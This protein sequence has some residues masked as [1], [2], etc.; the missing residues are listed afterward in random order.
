MT[1]QLNSKVVAAEAAKALKDDFRGNIVL[2]GEPSYEQARKVWNGMIDKHP[3]I[4]LRCAGTSDVMKAVRFA[5]D[6]G[7][8]VSVR[9]GGHNVAGN[10]VCDDGLMIDLSGMKS[11]RVD[12]VS[13]TVRVEPGATW[14][15]FD[16]E[17]QAFG[18]AATGGLVSTTGIAGFTL[19]G[20]IGWLVRKYGLALDN[21]VSVDVV[22]ARSEL[23]TASMSENTDLFWG[24][25]GGG[26]NF[27]IVT[28]FE[29]QLYPVGPIV[30]G[31]LIAYKAEDGQA[32]LRFYRDYVK[33]APDELTTI[34]VYLTAPP[35]PFLPKEVHGT[36]LLAIAVCYCGGIE[37]GQRVLAPLRKFGKPV[38]DVIQPL[39]Y[40]VLQSMLD[41]TSPAGIQN[42][43]KS[44]YISDLSDDAID[45]ILS[46][47]KKIASPLSAVHMHQ[48]GGAMRRVGD[49]A[50]AFSHRDASCLLNIVS[51]WQDPVE[52]EKQIK[53]T[54]DF[55]AA[56]KR[57]SIGAY[58]NFLGE[59]GA[60]RVKEAY[61][62][63][64]YEKLVALKDKYDPTNFFHLNQNIRPSH[65][66]A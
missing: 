24:V 63:E 65:P 32:L 47:G 50:T 19:G 53:W 39:P 35:L 1:T 3:A 61:E 30:L 9:G 55:F 54:R 33:D 66:S 5:H 12:P 36:H 4:I 41:E 17:T 52:N 11:V 25:R 27:G 31:G 46:Y 18:L 34:A 28:S 16:L 51:A 29:Y 45:V 26:G 60:D 7:L 8:V 2:P 38:A 48:L 57:F 40:V 6:Q 37:E 23:L 10:A 14:R 62:E 15:Q 20:G 13:R 22:T 58:V 64:K 43:W 44:S 59:E 56:M 42:Y 21:L 49:D